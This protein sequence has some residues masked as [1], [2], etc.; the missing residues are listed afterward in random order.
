MNA[1]PIQ[2]VK[3]SILSG[4]SKATDNIE[5][6]NQRMMRVLAVVAPEEGEAH[7]SEERNH[8]TTSQPAT[9]F[10]VGSTT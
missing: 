9:I 1:V 6:V 2:R 5:V 10:S 8:T 3:Q 7:K 4:R